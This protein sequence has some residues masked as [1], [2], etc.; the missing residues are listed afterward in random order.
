MSSFARAQLCVGGGIG[1]GQ[2]SD[3]KLTVNISP[4]VSYYVSNSFAL[5]GRLSYYSG[6][7]RF[8]VD[9]YIRWHM[10]KPSRIVRILATVHAPVAFASEYSSYGFYF[11]PGISFRLG[12]NVRLECHV[13]AFGWGSVK[14][15]D[16]TYSGWEARINSS[17][18]TFGVVFS[19]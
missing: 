9:P 11:Q 16:R 17:N 3:G 12:S 10:L 1:F 14:Y 18:I 19:I 4:E 2:G 6:D 8:T 5:G 13:G 15:A 7:N